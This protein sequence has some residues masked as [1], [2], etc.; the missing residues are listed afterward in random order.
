[1]RTDGRIEGGKEMPWENVFS[2]LKNY[3]QGELTVV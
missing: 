1:M 3:L 2:Y